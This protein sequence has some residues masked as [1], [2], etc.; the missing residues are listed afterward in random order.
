MLGS[1]EAMMSVVVVVNGEEVRGGVAMIKD[2][3]VDSTM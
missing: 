2:V 3:N 1:D